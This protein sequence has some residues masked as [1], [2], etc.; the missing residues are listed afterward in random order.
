MDFIPPLSS[1]VDIISYVDRLIARSVFFEAW[2]GSKLVGMV[3]AYLNDMNS[4]TGF[5]TNVSILKTYTRMGIASTLLEKC[6]EYALKCGYKRIK[7][8]VAQE[9][10]PAIELYSKMGFKIIAESK[11]NFLMEINIADKKQ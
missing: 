3:N 1:R 9:N 10:N 4:Q 6:F 7:L 5:I 11:H 8:E 2:D